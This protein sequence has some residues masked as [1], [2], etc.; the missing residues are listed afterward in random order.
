M[1]LELLAHL[2]FSTM[3][4]LHNIYEQLKEEGGTRRQL[5]GYSPSRG[6]SDTYLH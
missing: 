1:V 5:N 6:D 4:D 3:T 2:V